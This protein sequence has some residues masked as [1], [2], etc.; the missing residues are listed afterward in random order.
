M[1]H[2]YDSRVKCLS[3]CLSLVYDYMTVYLLSIFA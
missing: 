1:I 3:V 2:V